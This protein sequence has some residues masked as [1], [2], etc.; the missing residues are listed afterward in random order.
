MDLIIDHLDLDRFPEELKEIALDPD[1]GRRLKA[2]SL[3]RKK[4]G[5]TLQEAV[6]AVEKLSGRKFKS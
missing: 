5:A 3:Y 1:P 6:E 2:V 4:T